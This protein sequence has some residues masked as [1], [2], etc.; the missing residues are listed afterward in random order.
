MAT[1]KKVK[2]QSIDPENVITTE[3]V[4]IPETVENPI[5]L[6][7][8]IVETKDI[9]IEKPK[10]NV[11]L[12]EAKKD[13]L[14]T[15]SEATGLHLSGSGHTKREE[16]VTQEKYD[17]LLATFNKLCARVGLDLQHEKALRAEAG[18]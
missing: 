12:V 16:L 11:V 18:L 4:E 3:T 5:E 6:D 14:L 1:K 17:L 7:D 9:E 8:P 15:S 2:G 10:K 13:R